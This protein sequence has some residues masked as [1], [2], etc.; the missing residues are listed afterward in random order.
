MT[1]QK[2]KKK[3]FLNSKKCT[4]KSESIS[5][6]T[7]PKHVAIIMD[8]NG[9]WA[10]KRF[11]KRIFGHEK[12]AETVRMVTRTSRELG[13]SV[14]TL[15]AFS[16]ENWQRPQ[17]EINAL[18]KLLIKYLNTERQE[19]LDNNIR[20]QSIGHIENM[21]ADV[22]DALNR[23][24]EA[25][26]HNDGMI[27]NL[28]LSYGGRADIVQAV[29]S[30]ASRCVQNELTIDDISES[31]INDN[32]FT[33]ALSQSD[34]DLLIRTGGDFRVSN[35]LL[36]QI[37]YSELFFTPTLWPDFSKEEF[38]SILNHYQSR[39]RRFGKTGDQI[40]GT[41]RLSQTNTD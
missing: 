32:L 10:Q 38:L 27:L 35:F 7:I 24:K 39:E 4:T 21:P 34:P 23:T 30:I 29:R 12:G 41:D 3:K 2:L 37:A 16:T 15:Y 18:M 20:L 22:Q 11:W 28:A 36:W 17:D 19:M 8:G 31:L 33:N 9:R 40:K 14:L 26:N 5:L 1:L 25:T 13:I 6:L